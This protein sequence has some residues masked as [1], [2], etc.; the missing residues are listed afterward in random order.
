MKIATLHVAGAFAERL[1]I[2]LVFSL[3]PV[4]AH[5]DLQYHQIKSFGFPDQMGVSPRAPL[6]EGTDGLLY[7]TSY[8]GAP[9]DSGTV[10]E[11]NKD[12]SGYRVLHRFGS[13]DKDG[14]FPQAALVKGSDGALYGTTS[15]G[16]SNCC[17]EV[18]YGGTVFKLNRDGSGYQMLRSFGG[19]ND[20]ENLQCELIEG[21]DGALYGTTTDGGATRG[22]TVFTL[23]KDGSGY[24]ILYNFSS[25]ARP[26]AGLT[27]GSDGALYGTAERDGTA[28]AGTVFRIN[29]AGSGYSVVHNFTGSYGFNGS[30]GAFPHA[31]LLQGSDGSLYG[32]TTIGG[33][34][35][36]GT[37][38]KLNLDGNGYR[39][40]HS[41]NI[42]DADGYY[43]NGQLVEGTN[44]MLYGTTPNGGTNGSGTIFALKEDGA[45]FSILH[46]FSY[47][48]F[49]GDFPS[50][51]LLKGDDGTLYGTAASGG[52]NAVGT[53]FR[54]NED[55]TGYR[56]SRSFIYAGG[57]GVSP[58]AGLI[59]GRDGSLYG[60][61]ANGGTG[62]CQGTS[63][64]FGCGTVFG[65]N[66]D[67][68]GHRILHLFGS[69]SDEG[70]APD[71]GLL[72]G[73]DGALYGTTVSGG[74]NDDGTVFKLAPSGS[75]YTVLHHFTANGGDGAGP[76]AELIQGSDGALYGTTSGGGSNYSG[77]VFKLNT[78]G[79]GHVTLHS[80][81]FGDGRPR[82]RLVEGGDGVLYGTTP[83]GG[84]NHFG[85]VFKLNKDGGGYIILHSF[86][87]N[88]VDGV[89]PYA[90]LLEANDGALYG[91]TTQGGA[92]N[93]GTVFRLSKDG[94]DYRVLHSFG[95]FYGT[96][97]E[98]PAG[99]LVE[100]SDGALYGTTVYGGDHACSDGCGT[101]FKLNRDGSG[102]ANSSFGA[103]GGGGINPVSGLILG[104]DGA[105]YGTTRAGGDLGLGTVFRLSSSGNKPPVPII[106][107]SP[108]VRFPGQSN[109]TV[110]ASDNI[111]V[112][113]TFD[114][115]KSSDPDDATFSYFWSEGGTLF[116]T[117]TIATRA[118][119]VGTH[120]ITLLLDDGHPQGTSSATVP[121]EVI[122]PTDAVRIA[123]GLVEN[124]SLPDHRRQPLIVSL[125]ASAASFTRGSFV[126]GVNQLR[127]FQ[128][129]LQ[130]QVAASN[131]TLAQQL[132]YAAG[133]II[134]AV[135]AKKS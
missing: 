45:S 70:Q 132:S 22:G 30:D 98:T 131:P 64:Q 37:V 25:F 92:N 114:A 66:R 59:E 74:S 109:P 14:F 94:T 50:A 61:T 81:T 8:G 108:L 38:F 75:G 34:T 84:S 15:K 119:S 1:L 110:I 13:I 18:L 87:Y 101:V 54:L 65:L 44:G 122:S 72:Q 11:L 31:T 5:A 41:F 77:T 39:T 105:L 91:T 28:G 133:I 100:G 88:G 69:S 102:Y 7:G 107:V 86:N 112:L 33:A 85:S 79:S 58:Q 111:S 90:G 62:G 20:G 26:F 24:S 42:Y 55:G 56:T 12:G 118:L 130:A 128:N 127:A 48:G 68:S 52:S 63:G 6:I 96:D 27:E 82:A 124:S 4:V 32:T 35:N 29:K 123:L 97:G 117:N 47:A 115:S 16:G 43:P 126:A 121:V 93:D 76:Q 83:E 89:R 106:E 95:P 17:G 49:D 120:A 46:R 125:N 67:G 36:S 2:I 73:S 113:V 135:T 9:G 103:T 78:D 80:F 60:T 23:K 71:A 51:G 19:G 129:K 53:V 99:G 134:D 3:L 21:S 40:L 104:G 10:F 57:D 116:S